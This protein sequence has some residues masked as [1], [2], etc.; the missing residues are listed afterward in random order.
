M[1][2]DSPYA[3][4][5]ASF[6]PLGGERS[7]EFAIVG[8]GITGLSAALHLAEAGRS[9]VLLEARQPGWGA[10]GRN[11]GQVNPG[12]KS[13]PSQVLRDFGPRFGPALVE[14]AWSAPDVVF[15]LIARHR[16]A[17]GA[18]R[19][20]TI[21][22][23]TEPAQ[24]APLRELTAQCADLG[25]PVMWLDAEAI[26]QRTGTAR[27][28]GGMIDPAGGQLDPL[29]YTA[30]LAA[31]ATRAGAVIH[32]ETP[33]LRLQSASG[34][35]ALSTPAGGVK[36]PTVL[37]ATNGYS[38][39]L[40]GRLARS[41]VP[42]YSAIAATAPLPA[43]LRARIL[44]RR[45]VLYELGGITVYYR[46]DAEGRLLVGG[47]SRSRDLSGPAD[48]PH[49]VRLAGRLWPDLAGV[50]WTHGWN[51]QLALTLDHYPHWHNPQP[52]LVAVL[53]YNGRGVAFA[54]T[55][56]RALARMWLDDAPPLLPFTPVR[57][58]PMHSGWRLAVAARLALGRL[59][60]AG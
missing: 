4:P 15:D 9:V 12:L 14:A 48:L 38:G 56:G 55:C 57:P 30:G 11:G 41:V 16:I 27:Y 44:A 33:V 23:A 47:R 31:A 52:G 24:L 22:A 2:I 18:V 6:A 26:A 50:A 39:R 43:E 46:V 60:R 3:A 29:A 1:E 59:G 53:G 36:A 58:I 42:V 34:A 37:V 10:S 20:G 21:R 54:T 13:A 19:G 5:A 25:R 28:V 51:G 17:C 35:W 32:G 49:L 45:E 40:W 8:G 7:A